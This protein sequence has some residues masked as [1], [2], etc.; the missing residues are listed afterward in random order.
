MVKLC[1]AK[2][3]VVLL[4]DYMLNTRRACPQVEIARHINLHN[5]VARLYRRLVHD[6]QSL[7]L[8]FEE[9]SLEC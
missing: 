2:N 6:R 3:I 4:Q 1:A 9:S 5:I 8:F 7:T